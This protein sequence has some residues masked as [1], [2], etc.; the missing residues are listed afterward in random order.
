MFSGNGI[1]SF[2]IKELTVKYF[3]FFFILFLLKKEGDSF[4][5]ISFFTSIK[6][7][8]SAIS[9]DFVNLIMIKQNDFKRILHN[10]H[11]YVQRII[12]FMEFFFIL[13]SF[14]PIKGSHSN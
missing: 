14:F 7:E 10:S 3:S 6:R 5:E 11:D 12:I 2:H 8:S 9:K 4:G 1:K 13:G